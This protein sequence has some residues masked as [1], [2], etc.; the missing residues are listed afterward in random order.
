MARRSLIQNSCRRSVRQP[1]DNWADA[2][3]NWCASVRRPAKRLTDKMPSNYYFLGLIHLA[4][5]NAKIIHT[6]RDPIDTCISCFSKLFSADQNHTYDLAELGRYYRRYEQLMTHWRRVLPT[7]SFLDV[8]YEDVVANLEG[9][10]R[11]IIAY[12]GLP[13][14]DRCLAFHETNRPCERRAQRRCANPFTKTQLAA[15]VCTKSSLD[16]C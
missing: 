7:E 16:L 3:S 9:A 11:R 15:G 2:I 1:C 12:C 6:V 8:Q 4:L 10:A 5:P 13:W 14:D